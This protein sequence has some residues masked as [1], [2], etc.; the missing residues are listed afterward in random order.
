MRCLRTAGEKKYMKDIK[1]VCVP[2]LTST[3][4]KLKDVC[5][6]N[7]TKAAVEAAIE[8]R[9]RAGRQP[10][11]VWNMQGMMEAISK[12]IEGATTVIIVFYDVDA[13]ELHLGE[14]DLTQKK[15]KQI[16]FEEG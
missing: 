15:Y 12:N 16:L 9:I 7:E 2:L 1:H 8:Y 5:D 14:V 13:S 3:I 6:T 10:G 4:A 11:T